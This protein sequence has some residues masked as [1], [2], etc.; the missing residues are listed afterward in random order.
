MVLSGYILY[1][2]DSPKRCAHD[3]QAE[4]CVAGADADLYAGNGYSTR[5]AAQVTELDYTWYARSV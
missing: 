5:F 3:R 2:P 4:H 1:P